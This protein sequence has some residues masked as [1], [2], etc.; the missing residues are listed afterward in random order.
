MTSWTQ[1]HKRR[2]TCGLYPGVWAQL[3]L[4]VCPQYL[5]ARYRPFVSRDRPMVS[6]SNMWQNSKTHRHFQLWSIKRVDWKL[7][8]SYNFGLLLA[9]IATYCILLHIIGYIRP[10]TSHTLTHS[11]RIANGK[12]ATFRK[13]RQQRLRRLG[14]ICSKRFLVSFNA[15]LRVSR[16]N[17]RNKDRIPKYVHPTNSSLE[18][19]LFEH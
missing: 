2:S 14:T 13:R 12:R 9:L 16:W 18:T 1:Q 3:F 10:C 17:T 15:W 19:F 6:V 4:G 5:D 8:F 11:T 7:S